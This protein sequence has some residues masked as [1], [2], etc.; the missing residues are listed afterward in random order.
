MKLSPQT[1]ETLQANQANVRNICIL[2]HVDHGKTSLS[3]S[4]LATNGIISQRMAGKVRFLDSREDEQLRG[5][6]MESSAI[7]L[8][9]KILR[10]K[11]NTEA[12]ETNEYLIN[13]IDSPGHIDF[14]SEVSSAARLCDGA[15]VLVDSV[16]GV[17]SQTINVLRQCWVDRIKP[18]LVVNKID[19][20]I[21]E[22]RMT[23]LEAYLHISKIIEQVNVVMASFFSGDRMQDDL[24]WRESGSREAYVE[25]SDSDL[26][27]APEK[28]NVI[29]ASAIDGWAFSV[30]TFAKIYLA[31]LGFSQSVLAKTLWGDFYLD[32]KNKKILPGSK[33]KPSQLSLKPLFVSLILEQIWSIYDACVVERDEEK[34]Q[35][36]VAKLNARVSPRDMRSSDHKSL[37]NVI[38]SQWIPLSHSLLGAVIEY[39]P[40]PQKAQQDRMEN[41]L[42]EVLY[43][44]ITDPTVDKNSLIEPD[45]KSAMVNCEVSNPDVHTLA[46]VS[47]MISVPESE[48]P[49]EIVQKLS[50]EEVLEKQ[51]KVREKARQAEVAAAAAALEAAKLADGDDI[52]LE[53]RPDQFQWEFEDDEDA[54]AEEELEKE[55]LVAFTRIYAGELSK[56]Q[57]VCV[58]GARYDPS[59]PKTHPTNLEQLREDIEIEDLLLLMGREFVRVNSVPAGNIVGVVG[60][61]DFV[62]KNATI[63][64][65]VPEGKPYLNMASTS[66]LIHNKPIVSVA[67]EPQDPFKLFKLEKGLDLLSKADPVLEWYV[68]D[69][70]GEL[71]VCVA[72]ELHLERCLNDLQKRFAPG[73]DVTIKEP[74]IPFREGLSYTDEVTKIPEDDASD[75]EDAEVSREE[76]D[77]QLEVHPMSPELCKFLTEHENEIRE[78]V[79]FKLKNSTKDASEHSLELREKLKNAL[80][81]TELDAKILEVFGTIDS[82]IDRIISF[83]PKRIGPNFFV[84]EPTNGSQ[85][86][87]VFGE[88]SDEKFEFESNVLSGYQLAMN[89][90]PLASEPIQGTITVLKKTYKPE[91]EEL[92][93]NLG[94]RVLKRTKQLVH[95]SFLKR[96][97]RLFLA[98][99][100]CEI[101]TSPEVLGKVYAVVQKRGGS[102]ISE[103]LKEGTPFFTIGARIPVVEAFG[104]SEEIRKRTSGAA[105]PQLVFDGFDMLDIDPFWIPR[106]EE[107]LEELGKFEERE[108][109]GRRYMNTIRRRKGLFV[110]EKVVKNAEKQRTLK[111]D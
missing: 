105:S 24:N 106:T 63:M 47:K 50:S 29:F 20:L 60:L 53:T 95:T 17:S 58:V 74:V 54:E 57:K 93:L 55:V 42:D 32:M 10:R 52:Y 2:A 37:L 27:F 34:L 39:L 4:L 98:M 23:P 67:I 30:N 13:L 11:E 44:A 7:S 104:F 1:V 111:R 76:L 71:I 9:F 86:R 16:E 94:G 89:D 77:L 68:D 22:W 45:F 85:F 87:R 66:T 75:A 36:I 38:M 97:P 100:T 8:Y 61:G 56:G 6:T 72:G 46:Y 31:K 103:E 84:E 90:G 41:T 73:C 96:S 26:Y 62:L 43:S 65:E 18:L 110:D 92:L 49:K 108:N 102:I 21:T 19:R 88:E 25:R 107:E 3:D 12:V 40:G 14:S 78:V 48:L 81:E 80:Q 51:K 33:L 5:I 64:S 70:S 91:S 99:Y 35:K 59:L 82:F 109:V 15:V 83:G 69:D 28:N 101:Q 79:A